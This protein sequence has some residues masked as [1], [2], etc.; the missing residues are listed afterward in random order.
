MGFSVGSLHHL[1]TLGRSG[2]IPRACRYLDF[3]SQNLFGEFPRPQVEDFLAVF[4][5][6]DRYSPNLTQPS[7]KIEALMAAADFDY[8]AFDMYTHSRTRKLDLNF[9]SL[10]DSMCGTFDVVANFGT[11]EHVSNQYNVFKVAHDALKVGGVMYS[12]LPFFG[13]IDHGLLNYHPKFFTTLITNNSYQPL[14]WDFSDVFAGGADSY[15]NLL[16]AGNGSA[17]E[18]KYVGSALMNVIFKRTTSAPFR[19]PTDSVLAG[20]ISLGYPTVNEILERA[21]SWNPLT[22]L[23]S[24][25]SE[26]AASV[27]SSNREAIG[28]ENG[29]RTEFDWMRLNAELERLKDRLKHEEREVKELRSSKSWRVTA[30]LRSA[31]RWVRRLRA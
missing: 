23:E 17:W 29:N 30:P 13:G 22:T 20:D 2:H 31:A 15:R 16:T 5:S 10:P 19:P 6:R 9:D 18:G 1:T 7:A 4:S 11:S 12:T 8:I 25:N 21:P 3:G 14:Y 27:P 26:V 28:R 24:S